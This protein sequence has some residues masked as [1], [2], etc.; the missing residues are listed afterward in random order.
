M[1]TLSVKE[2]EPMPTLTRDENINIYY[3]EYGTG[4]PILLFAPGGMRSSLDF[5]PKSQWDPIKELAPHFHVIAMDQRNAGSST[6]PITANDG[7]QSYTED[8]I[9]LLDHLNIDRCHLLGGCI[10]GPYCFGVMEAAP[11][12]VASV[13]LQQTIGLENNRQAFYE[14]FDSWAEQLKNDRPDL[15]GDLNDETLQ[16]FRSNMY[17]GEFVFNVSPEFVGR[18]QT[19]MLILMGKDLYHPE[20]TSREIARLAPNASLIEHWKEPDVIPQTIA[21]VVEFLQRNTQV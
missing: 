15:D 3:E 10:G 14:M 4:F 20:S 9:A 12:R 18:C 11:D 8:H 19:P 21:S 1:Q 17:D 16:Q 6:A 2:G 7:W 13:V 5:W